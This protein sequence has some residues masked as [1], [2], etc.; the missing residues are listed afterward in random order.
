MRFTKYFKLKREG[1]LIEAGVLRL[2]DKKDWKNNIE[3]EVNK[4]LDYHKDQMR[5]NKQMVGS[6]GAQAVAHVRTMKRIDQVL[7]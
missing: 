3:N 6:S 5:L 2:Q 1:K 7:V 4:S